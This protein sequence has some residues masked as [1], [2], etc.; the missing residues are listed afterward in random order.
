L[1]SLTDQLRPATQVHQLHHFQ[2]NYQLDVK[3]PFSS[4]DR[5]VDSFRKL[6]WLIAERVKQEL[7]DSYF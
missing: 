2:L 3:L 7:A 5:E 1:S 4:K 6:N